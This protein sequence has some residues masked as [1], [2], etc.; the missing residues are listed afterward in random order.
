MT[1][2]L[3]GRRVLKALLFVLLPI[4][5]GVAS[6][7]ALPAISSRFGAD[8]WAAIAVGSAVGMSMSVFVELGWVVN[9]PVRAARAVGRS[10]ARLYVLST[11]T[12]AGT[13]LPVA[14]VASVLG[15]FLAPTFPLEAALAAAMGTA[16]G[17][18]PAWFFIGRG[19]PGIVLLVDVL[20]RVLFAGASALAISTGGALAIYP[21]ALL[22]AAVVSVL[23][24]L[25]A[26]EV[27][28]EDLRAIS[29][30]RILFTMRRQSIALRG[31][32]ASALYVGL[33]IVLVSIAAPAAVAIFSSAERLQRMALAVLRS[34]P[35][36]MV[37]WVASPSS[38]H[39]RARRTRRAILVNVLAGIVAGAAFALLAPA[40][41]DLVFAGV[42][43]LPLHLSAL[44]GVVIALVSTSRA[45]G[46]IGLV[47]Y[48]RVD[49]LSAS[50]IWGAVAG[51]PA[52][53][54]LSFRLGSAGGLLGEIVA[55]T[56]VLVRQ[57]FGLAKQMAGRRH[58]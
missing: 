51:I 29:R 25:V 20:P 3:G 46:G 12:K 2:R 43:E 54:A 40:L 30:T 9:G 6:L 22:V 7:L 57:A 19:Q 11:L 1:E 26:A 5:S 56:V 44:C 16:L 55:E 10:A 35:N 31:Q 45:V 18:S 21:L 49:V 53:L 17:L 58:G 52:I 48:G 24:G 14:L 13:L 47:V 33:P 8:G 50:A 15:Y 23:F 34:L 27:R 32:I 42:I 41:A 28:P 36:L 39:E 37:N 4:A 38:W